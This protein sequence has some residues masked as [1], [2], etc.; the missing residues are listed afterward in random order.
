MSRLERRHFLKTSSTLLVGTSLAGK[1]AA[2]AGANDRIRVA[3]IGAG[4]RGRGLMYEASDVDGVEV[5]VICDPDERRMAEKAAELEKKT[6]KRPKTEP[7]LRRVLEDPQIDVVTVASCDHWHALATIWA[8]Q[9]GKHVY[10]EKPVCHNLF[11]GQKMVEAARKYDRIV[12]AGTQRRSN[13]SFRKAAQLIQEGVIGD[14]YW[15]NWVFPSPRAPIGFKEV[16]SVPSWLH[17]DLWL[18]PAPRRPYHA[19]L[20]HYNWQWFWDFGNGELA[21][22]GIH[23]MDIARWCLN[24]KELPSRIHSMGGRFGPADQAETPNAQRAN[25][26]YE[27]GTLLSCDF[28]NLYSAQGRV[29]PRTQSEPNP[30]RWWLEEWFWGFYGSKGYMHLKP[31]QSRGGRPPRQ[32]ARYYGCEYQIFLGRN[33]EPE[34]DRGILEHVDHYTNFIEAVRAGKREMLMAELEEGVVSTSLCLLANISLRLGRELHFDTKTRRFKGDPEAD[35]L[36]T[37]E[38]R[39]PFVV[40]DKV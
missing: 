13:G 9:A 4:I 40:P 11:E 15:A 37:R 26:V 39:E 3:L 17:W 10:V 22:N 34:P 27:D 23:L 2:W 25:F 12:Q 29:R 6:G 18:G 38:Y 7:D 14:V 20:V 5:A 35:R 1:S 32:L 28:R 30:K 16:E 8:C 19:N 24:K 33:P 21:T 36:L 31:S